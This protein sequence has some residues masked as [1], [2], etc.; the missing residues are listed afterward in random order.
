[1]SKNPKT[2]HFIDKVTNIKF[3]KYVFHQ[4]PEQAPSSECGILY[5]LRREGSSHII[6]NYQFPQRQ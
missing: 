3:E 4:H 2:L 1:M 5:Y 6:I